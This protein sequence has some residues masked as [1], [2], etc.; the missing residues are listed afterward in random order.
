VAFPPSPVEALRRNAM[1][2]NVSSMNKALLAAAMIGAAGCATESELFQPSAD[3]R[4]CAEA[5][6]QNQKG[7]PAWRDTLDRIQDRH[8]AWYC[9]NY[10]IAGDNGFIQGGP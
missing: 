9:L 10:L 3:D 5:R 1:S 6:W 2:A 7:D 8:T 4:L